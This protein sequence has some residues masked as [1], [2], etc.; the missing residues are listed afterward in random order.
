MSVLVAFLIMFIPILLVY[1]MVDFL[2]YKNWTSVYTA[3]DDENY[4]KVVGKL[5]QE[6]IPYKTRSQINLT[7]TPFGGNRQRHYE[8]YVKKE[9]ANKA[10]HKLN[11]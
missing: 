2:S 3:L 9:D 10:F 5:K 11:S 7:T 8:I 1:G 6:G 4:F